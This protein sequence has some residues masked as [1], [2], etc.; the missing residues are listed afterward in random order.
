MLPGDLAARALGVG[1]DAIVAIEPIRH[2]LTNRS[3][4]VR[5]HADAVVVRINSPHWASLQ[6]DR[7][8]EASVLDAV[9]A[10]GIGA[11]LVVR[12]VEQG[13]LITRYVGPTCTAERMREPDFIDRLGERFR[14]LHALGPPRNARA[15]HLP[16]LI[17]GYLDTLRTFGV[18]TPLLEP[19]VRA[20]GLVLASEIAET[21]TPRLCHNDV[22]YL[23]VVDAQPLRLI[24]WEYAGLGEPMFDLAS[25]CVYHDYSPEERDRL[26]SAYL[27]ASPDSQRDRLAKCCWLFEYVRDLWSAVRSAV[28]ERPA[29]DVRRS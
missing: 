4:I 29:A 13:V 26:L 17:D 25:V 15:V 21:S 20:R 7:L 27:Q 6:I 1:R 3:W 8:S 10:A 5:T 23:N 24:D 11:P 12:D 16:T 22:H 2:G 28:D 14:A 18:R 9:A 19:H